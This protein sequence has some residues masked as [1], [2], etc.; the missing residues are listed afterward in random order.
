MNENIEIPT[1]WYRLTD[2]TVIEKGDR[3]VYG[4]SVTDC[5][6]SIGSLVGSGQRLIA[7]TPVIRHVSKRPAPL[8]INN[9][10]SDLIAKLKVAIVN[11]GHSNVKVSVSSDSEVK[12][13]KKNE[14]TA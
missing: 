5:S 2:G 12:T 4:G 3:F 1:N 9:E 8:Y 10:V 13:V 7:S 11:A 6:D 14:F